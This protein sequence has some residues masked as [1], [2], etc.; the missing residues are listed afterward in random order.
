MGFLNS[1]FLYYLAFAS[2]PIIIHILNKQ[3]YKRIKWAAMEYLRLAL[4][5]VRRRIQ[6]EELLLLIIRTLIV[7][8]LVGAFAKPYI[9]SSKLAFLGGESK[10]YIFVLDSTLSMSLARDGISNFQKAKENLIKFIDGISQNPQNRIS[11]ILFKKPIE[12]LVRE[13]ISDFERAKQLITEINISKTSG[14]IKQLFS[15]IE[16]LVV[17]EKTADMVKEIYFLTDLQSYH[18]RQV[19]ED[20]EFKEN[21]AKIFKNNGRITIVDFGKEEYKNVT[22]TKL[23]SNKRIVFKNV[24]N[25]FIVS[26]KNNS[27]HSAQ[28]VK[29]DIFADK[30]KIGEKNISLPPLTS[31]NIMV[32]YNATKG[33]SH[34]LQAKIS[35]DDLPEDNIYNH[36]FNVPEK[37]NILVINGNPTTNV[38]DDEVFF[39]TRLINPCQ[40][41]DST[42]EKKECEKNINRPYHYEIK[43]AE[44]LETTILS[45]YD[46]VIIANLNMLSGKAVENIDNYLKN[47]GV[48]IFFLGNK[49]QSDSYNR[50]FFKSN[51]NIMPCQLIEKLDFSNISTSTEE[52]VRIGSIDLFHPVIVP[53]KDVFKKY[54]PTLRFDGFWRLK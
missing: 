51:N 5:K 4:Q 32:E 42:E 18:W 27:P 19:L 29:L 15:E 40:K 25:Q 2:I 17:S 26:V 10:Y 22:I 39:L 11:I 21:I 43:L 47:G 54:L 36:V 30:L 12:N 23:Y 31:D 50:S 9:K 41:L 8:L 53:N 38:F 13:P 20:E 46:L 37:I 52:F 33:G 24:T 1:G 16:Q 49:V 35:E 45:S 7:A 44:E 28:V 34:F 3:R 14:N 6:M 48:L